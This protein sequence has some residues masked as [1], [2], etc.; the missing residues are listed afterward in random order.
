[1]PDRKLCENHAFPAARPKEATGR[2][3][4]IAATKKKIAAEAKVS[5][6]SLEE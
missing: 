3:A 2:R 4:A 1:M 6:K 5:D